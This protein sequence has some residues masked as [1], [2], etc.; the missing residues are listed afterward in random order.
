[1]QEAA[2]AE[3]KALEADT[4]TDQPSGSVNIPAQ[5]TK[6]QEAYIAKRQELLDK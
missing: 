2:A 5:I 3:A 1:M 4:A 6:S